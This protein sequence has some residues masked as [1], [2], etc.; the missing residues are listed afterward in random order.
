MQN[1][2]TNTKLGK[3]RLRLAVVDY[4]IGTVGT[5]LG[6]RVRRGHM[7]WAPWELWGQLL[8]FCTC[9]WAFYSQTV[10]VNDHFRLFH[11]WKNEI[12]TT[13]SDKCLNALSLMAT[14]S[15]LLWNLDF[16]NILAQ[17]KTVPSITLPN[18]SRRLYILLSS[19]LYFYRSS[20]FPD[21]RAAP[22]KTIS[23]VA[24]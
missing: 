10:W 5:C 20:N 3:I 12:F 18:G 1:L 19:F 4:N 24:S 16:K 23:E 8:W 21:C 15:D 13:M 2:F 11:W 9:T 7:S 22:V 14:K 6:P 17:C